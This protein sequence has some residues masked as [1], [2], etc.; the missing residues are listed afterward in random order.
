M[1]VS[2]RERERPLGAALAQFHNLEGFRGYGLGRE[3][4]TNN[5]PAQGD[6]HMALREYL[7]ELRESSVV[8][9]EHVR[10]TRDLRMRVTER[11]MAAGAKP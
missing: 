2:K 10:D 11:I 6:T 7:K 9:R 1:K 3:A 8:F 4:L 5:P